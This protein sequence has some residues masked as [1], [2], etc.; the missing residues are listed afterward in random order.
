MGYHSIFSE[1]SKHNVQLIVVSKT[2]PADVVRGVY[3][4][5]HRHFGE[6]RVQELLLKA[7]ELPQDIRWHMIGSLQRNK[8]KFIAP[9][10]EL[11]QSCD[12]FALLDTIIKEGAK[13][14]RQLSVLLQ[15]HIATEETKHGFSDQ[16]L[17]KIFDYFSTGSRFVTVRGVMGMATFT[18]DES[19]LR[20]E[21]MRLKHIFDI[22]QPKFG[23]DFKEISMGM[24]GDYR[25]AIECG[26]T[27]VR[28]GSAIFG[29]RS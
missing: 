13:I 15:F 29:D 19:L 25:L 2:H 26:S 3:D 22:L 9:F 14:N 18:K 1:L 24:S 4:Q 16:D 5:G 27:M 28:I 7:S 10:V 12:S 8:V 20:S 6:N 21:F 11:I 23:E 17:D